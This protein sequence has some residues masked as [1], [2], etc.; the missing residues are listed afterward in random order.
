MTAAL[1]CPVH[2]PRTLEDQITELAAHICAATWQLLKLI[3]EYDLCS[4]WNCGGSK[5]CAHWLNWKCGI[6][7]GAAREKVRVAHALAELPQ[8]SAAFR[9][10]RVSYSKV[11]AMTRI[12]TPENEDYLLMIARHGTA[13]HVERLVRGYRRVG[14][15]QAQKQL[16]HRGL[17]HYVDE[18]GSV[19][20]RARLT[21][22]QGERLLLALETA[23][24]QLQRN[25]DDTATMRRADALERL[26][27]SYLTGAAQDSSGGDRY[28]LHVHT[29]IEDLGEPTD[30]DDVSAETSR[31]MACDC[32]VVNWLE[33]DRGQALDIGRR[34][35]N[36][37]PALRR[38]LQYRDGGCCFP[39]CTSHR[40]VDAHHIVHWADG[41]ETKLDNLVLLCRHH[42][43]L[44]HEGGYRVALSAAG[45]KQF[46][47]PNGHVVSHGPDARFRGNATALPASN[48]LRGLAITARTLPTLWRGERMD[49]GMAVYA[50][51]RRQS[52]ATRKSIPPATPMCHAW[53]DQD[54]VP[55]SPSCNR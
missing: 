46:T 36:I 51:L 44:V 28:T 47:A 16:E 53:P 33:T 14:R 20:I 55:E 32:G 6:A 7:L 54:V 22:E 30:A 24:E 39:G 17:S 21:P 15:L 25:D 12:A 4:G 31:R 9:E 11:R 40:H 2:D 42:H 52:T 5:S 38:A 43:R 23:A 8:I 48:T 13:S 19:V 1:P 26:A 34:S 37:T 18:D 29:K 27:E 3:R 10:G 45:D 35:R 41:G 50:L 49:L